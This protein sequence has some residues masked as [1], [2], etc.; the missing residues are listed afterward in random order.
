V[1]QVGEILTGEL[2]LEGLSNLL[3][4]ALEVDEAALDLRGVW[5]VVR[6]EHLAVDDGEID[7]DLVEP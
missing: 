1:E 6:G 3:V 7:L 2:P 5:E 4:A